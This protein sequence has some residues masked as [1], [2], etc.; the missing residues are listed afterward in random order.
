MKNVV[1]A[2]EYPGIEITM[3]TAACKRESSS[4][5]RKANSEYTTALSQ[6][7]VLFPFL[8]Q[9]RPGL[10]GRDSTSN[11]LFLCLMNSKF[12]SIITNH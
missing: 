5:G 6:Y 3:F 7:S 4:R 12:S 2:L 11:H 10:G 8:P 9:N 1:C